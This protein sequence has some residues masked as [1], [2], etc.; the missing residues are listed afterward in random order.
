MTYVEVRAALAAA[1]RARR[2]S[3][4][5][6]ARAQAGFDAFW[7]RFLVLDVDAAIAEAAA[8]IAERF[9][10][11]SHDAVQLASALRIEDPALTMIALDRRLLRA[12]SA[13][14]LEVTG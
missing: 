2:L 1:R 11:R 14:G 7:T 12:A 8:E 5:G 4:P 3:A 6:L 10:L 9:A 13:A